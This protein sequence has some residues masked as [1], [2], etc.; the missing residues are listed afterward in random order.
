MKLTTFFHLCFLL[1]F[2]TSEGARQ[3]VCAAVFTVFTLS[4]GVTPLLKCQ[5]IAV[6]NNASD[7]GVEKG[8]EK[9]LVGQC[10]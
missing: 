9:L 7:N 3:E 5:T 2:H 10:L 8:S 1:Y 4:T 6:D